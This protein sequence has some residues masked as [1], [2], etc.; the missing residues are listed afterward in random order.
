MIGIKGRSMPDICQGCP[1]FNVITADGKTDDE[2]KTMIFQFC[3]VTG[4]DLKKIDASNKI[5]NDWLHTERPEWCPLVDIPDITI[6]GTDLG[7]MMSDEDLSR[8]AERLRRHSY[9]F[10]S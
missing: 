7:R 9:R 3:R 2:Y 4:K 6:E 8:M 1:C 10:D 5:P